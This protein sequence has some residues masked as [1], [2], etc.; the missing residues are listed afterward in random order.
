MRN[1]RIVWKVVWIEYHLQLNL[2]YS[3]S[4]NVT[5]PISRVLIGLHLIFGSLTSPMCCN[6]TPKCMPVKYKK[7]QK[8]GFPGFPGY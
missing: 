1:G 5:P 4:N 6:L 8:P 2:T 3:A 7:G